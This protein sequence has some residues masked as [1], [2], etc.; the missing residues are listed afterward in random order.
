[1]SPE[2]VEYDWNGSAESFVVITARLFGEA[3]MKGKILIF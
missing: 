3:C 2:N 1:M